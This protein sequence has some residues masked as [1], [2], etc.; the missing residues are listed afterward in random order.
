MRYT[1]NALLQRGGGIGGFLRSAGRLIKKIVLPVAKK[2]VTSKAG[3]QSMKALARGAKDVLSNVVSG[4]SSENKQVVNR[5][6]KQVVSA[7]Q[8]GVIEAGVKRKNP[9][10]PKNK[11]S[12][13]KKNSFF[14]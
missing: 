6:K 2:A 5:V 9:K 3:K 13:K 4:D 11:K 14:D 8:K 7:L 1:Q 10:K 12:K